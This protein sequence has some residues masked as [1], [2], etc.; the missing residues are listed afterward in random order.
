MAWPRSRSRG[1]AG[2]TGEYYAQTTAER[3][4][5]MKF[6]RAAVA[7]REP[8]LIGV[9]AIRTEDCIAYAEAAAAGAIASASTGG[10]GEAA[11][12]VAS[13]VRHRA[14]WHGVGAGTAQHLIRDTSTQSPAPVRG[15]G[16]RSQS[17]SEATAVVSADFSRTA[18][19]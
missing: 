8:L 4:D 1:A 12:N 2:T 15:G 18:R 7:G 14:R 3:I 17:H 13:A 16:A 6:A 11:G 5:L 9:G 10:R 19:W